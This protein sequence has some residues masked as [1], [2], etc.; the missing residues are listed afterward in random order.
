MSVS[1]NHHHEVYHCL[2]MLAQDWQAEFLYMVNS[3]SGSEM[4]CI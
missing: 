4:A 3:A 2:A 1:P